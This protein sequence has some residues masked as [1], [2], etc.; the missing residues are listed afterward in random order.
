MGEG[1]S[2]SAQA[3]ARAPVDLSLAVAQ[4]FHNAPRLYGD[5]TVRRPTRVTGIHSGLKAAR[6]EFVYGVY[7]GVTGLVRLPVRG[8]RN[9]GGVKG[10]TKGVGMGITGFFLKDIAAIAGPIG[11]TL[12]GVAK[13]VERGKQPIKLI[14]RGR[15]VQ[16]QRELQGLSEEEH[17][18]RAK[19]ALAGWDVMNSLWEAVEQRQKEKGGL[20]ARLGVNKKQRVV[21][22]AALESVEIAKQALDAVRRG[23]SVESVV[24]K[25]R[26][27]EEA[28]ANTRGRKSED[29]R[30]KSSDKRRSHE[31]VRDPDDILAKGK[32]K[33]A[34]TEPIEEEDSPAGQE[35][36]T[37]EHEK[38]PVI[39]GKA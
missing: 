34:I 11:Y 31:K 1:V 35:V 23:E 7:D 28:N 13:Q 39:N 10:F 26:K 19:D 29:G 25:Q 9:G 20:R 8:A 24:G 27:S 33:A 30:R 5:D 6:H 3:I 16:G 14:R 22:S 18:K 37:A 15:I 17:K 4:G 12:K 36:E 38:K 2:K 32:K 21:V